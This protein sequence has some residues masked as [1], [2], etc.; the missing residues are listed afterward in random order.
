[1]TQATDFKSWPEDWDRISVGDNGSLFYYAKHRR[2]GVS[3]IMN[4][5]NYQEPCF[6]EYRS[7][8][9]LQRLADG[10]LSLLDAIKKFMELHPSAEDDVKAEIER[11]KDKLKFEKDR[12]KEA[13]L[14][15]KAATKLSDMTENN[16]LTYRRLLR[17]GHFK[18]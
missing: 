11:L 4:T 12:A 3:I 16:L 6:W 2:R 10:S 14:G 13:E 15:Y 5:R 7:F 17:A 8:S 1:M 18:E 9:G